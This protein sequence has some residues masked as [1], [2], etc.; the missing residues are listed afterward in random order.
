LTLHFNGT[1]TR[2]TRNNEEIQTKTSTRTKMR[3][4]RN[5][6][7]YTRG[8]LAQMYSIVFE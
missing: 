1:D 2:I 5:G 4:Q 8:T 3:E 7:L 6:L